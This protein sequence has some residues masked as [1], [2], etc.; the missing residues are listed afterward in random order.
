MDILRAI[1]GILLIL[2]SSGSLLLGLMNPEAVIRWGN[3]KTRSRV[4][5]TYGLLLVLGVLLMPGETAR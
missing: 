5:L 3:T 1:L 2:V 4:L